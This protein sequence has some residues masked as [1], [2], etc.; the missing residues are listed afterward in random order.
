MQTRLWLASIAT[1]AVVAAGVF[2]ASPIAHGQAPQVPGTDTVPDSAALSRDISAAVKDALD[3]AG[4]ENAQFSIDDLQ[5]S[6]VTT[7]HLERVHRLLP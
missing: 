2:V 6:G 3:Q 1:V 7:T 5:V 4:L